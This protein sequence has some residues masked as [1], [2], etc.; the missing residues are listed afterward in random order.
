[1]IDKTG[2]ALYDQPVKYFSDGPFWLGLSALLAFA[3][4]AALVEPKKIISY[5]AP[6]IPRGIINGTLSLLY[7][8]TLMAYTIF[9]LP[10]TYHPALLLEQ[11]NGSDSAMYKLRDILNKMP[12]VTSFMALQSLC[13]VL[14]VNYT[15][16]TKY[17]A[18]KLLRLPMIVLIIACILR[19]WL[20]SERLAILELIIPGRYQ[21]VPL[22]RTET[23]LASACSAIWRFCRVRNILCR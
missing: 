4:S 11:F 14:H 2:F 3:T 18:P 23:D 8:V 21:I 7:L 13:V 22:R 19:A 17:P 20:W 6:A 10:I 12:G 16:L 1:M 15:R 9:L 5:T